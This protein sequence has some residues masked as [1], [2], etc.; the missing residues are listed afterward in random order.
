VPVEE[1][2]TASQAD[3]ARC[4]ARDRYRVRR[5]VDIFDPRFYGFFIDVRFC[6]F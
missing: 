2:S 1:P 5:G 4:P 3:I 6:R